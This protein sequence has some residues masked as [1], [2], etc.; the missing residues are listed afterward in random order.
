MKIKKFKTAM[1]VLS[2]ALLFLC[3][4]NFALAAGEEKVD[5]FASTIKMNADASVEV[6]ERI[7]YDFGQLQKHGIYRDVPV[8]YAARGG[9]YNVRLS[10]VSVADETGSAYEFTVL[11][12][13]NDKEIKI[14]NADTF[15]TGKKT[16]VISYRIKRVINYFGDS[17]ELYWNVTGNG[18]V[19]PITKA[20]ARVIFPGSLGQGNTQIKCFAGIAGST[21]ACDISQYIYAPDNSSAA[22]AN[23]SAQ[24]LAAGEGLTIV[25]G[26][27]KGAVY[28]PT[29]S[30]LF[31]ETLIDNVV[32]FVP[33]LMFFVAFF[34]W[35]KRGKDSAGRGTIIT[36]FDVPDN[37]TPAEAG[38][39]VDER[40]EQKELSAE[41]IELAVKGYLKIKRQEREVLFIKSAEYSFE[42]LKEADDALGEHEKTLLGGIFEKGDSV[43]LSDLK[44]TFYEKYN[45]FTKEV[46]DSVSLKGYF[47]KNPQEA[48]VKYFVIYLFFL[49]GIYIVIFSLLGVAFGVYAVLSFVISL[50]IAG[51]FSFVMPQKTEAG[52]LLKEKI[53]GL[54]NYLTVAEKDRL[55]FHNAPEKSPEQF[56]KLLPY[57][58]AL[59][60]EK[61][62]AKQFE[63]IYNISPT[64]YEDSR[65]FNNFTAIYF[66]DSLNDFRTDFNSSVVTSAAA[67]GSSGF[68]GGGFSG[69]GFGGGGGGSW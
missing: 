2:L 6:T 3:G 67:S 32:L 48:R 4:N 44:S 51:I 58:I 31:K 21:K 47:F 10:D 56:E 43:K 66:V 24:N 69:G 26:V 33:L 17:D 28:Q 15:V 19:V 49:A 35:R 18:F 63:G 39:I 20:S 23:F 13:G 8:R 54:K 7:D 53:L 55:E 62:W 25:V 57:A 38:T 27:P 11:S 30:E 42:K 14:G 65:G 37:V 50:I 12:S 46:Y 68:G 59:S 29:Q 5:N 64:W 36:E 40:C 41:I 45:L 60:V 52:V 34:I 1:S 22:G 61:K 16:Y 9:N